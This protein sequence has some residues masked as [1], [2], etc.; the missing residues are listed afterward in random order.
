[1]SIK[2]RFL[3]LSAASLLILSACNDKERVKTAT[4]T[5]AVNVAATVNGI[6][7]AKS[8]ID[9]LMEQHASKGQADSPEARKTIIDQ[10]AMQM[11]L[12]QEAIKKNLDKTPEVNDQ[13]ELTKEAI[14][15]DAYVQDYIKNNPISD[16]TLKAEYDKIKA[17]ME[18]SH[19]KQ[20]QPLPSFEKVKPQLLKHVQELNLKKVIDGMMAKAKIEIAAAPAVTPAK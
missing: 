18:N 12:S 17:Q 9:R 7:I 6:G 13:I 14:F 15:A 5:S 19:A 3:L 11:L 2:S 8:R 16:D 10:L 4:T 20:A 1:M